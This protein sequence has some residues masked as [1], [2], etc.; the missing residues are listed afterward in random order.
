[1][2]TLTTNIDPA[3]LQYR[4]ARAV[5]LVRQMQ[6]IAGDQSVATATK[7]LSLI[8]ALADMTAADLD[9]LHDLCTSPDF[10]TS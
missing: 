8:E 10:C 4:L 7:G 9:A 2:A 6:T 3:V 5:T 1:M